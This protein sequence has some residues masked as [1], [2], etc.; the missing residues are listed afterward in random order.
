ME[1]AEEFVGLGDDIIS[2]LSLGDSMTVRYG[3]S[4]IDHGSLHY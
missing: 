2:V 4:E 3:G 1:I